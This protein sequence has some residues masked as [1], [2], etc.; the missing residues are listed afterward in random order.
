[1]KHVVVHVPDGRLQRGW[2]K[3]EIIRFAILIEIGDVDEPPPGRQSRAVSGAE[4]NVVVHVSND[5]LPGAGIQQHEIRFAVAIEIEPARL[6]APHDE[7]VT[8]NI[9]AYAFRGGCGNVSALAGAVEGILHIQTRRRAETVAVI[10]AKVT[11]RILIKL[12]DVVEST[13]DREETLTARAGIPSI[14]ARPAE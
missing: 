12:N 8:D 1:D 2:V 5:G 9:Q 4:V 11:V 14:E 10:V 3:Q 6:P 13:I 7:L